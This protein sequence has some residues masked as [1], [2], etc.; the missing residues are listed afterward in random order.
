MGGSNSAAALGVY[1]ALG[2]AS[3]TNVPGSREAGVSWADSSG[4]FWM[5]GGGGVDSIG[6]HGSLNDLWEFNPGANQWTWVSGADIANTGGAYGM[7]G[8][9]DT[10]NIP[11]ARALGAQWADSA[12]NLW[13]FGGN[14]YVSST[15]YGSLNDLWEF[16]PATKEWTWVS[17]SNTANALAVYGTLGVAAPG[18]VPSGR[19]GNAGWRD[20]NGKLW[21]FG[22][23]DSAFNN[24]LWEFDPTSNEWTWMGGSNV[25]NQSGVYGTQG[26]ASANNIPGGREEFIGWTDKQGNFWV[27]GGWGVDITQPTGVGIFNDLWQ[28]NPATGAWTWVSG[29]NTSGAAGV[30]GTKGATSAANVPGARYA[31]AG[32]TDSTGN[33]WLFGGYSQTNNSTGNGLDF[34]DL[35]EFNITTK[36]WTWVSG[37]NT[38]E[39]SGVYGTLGV[40]AVGNTPGARELSTTWAD[41]SG[42]LWLFGGT[43]FSAGTDRNDLWRWG[44][45]Q[46]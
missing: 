4:N 36:Q 30:Y 34:N 44:L 10:S 8:V 41:G 12:G 26:V 45:T 19:F 14:G 31:S 1:G 15:T 16:N 24:D 17:G 5:F 27:F 3:P 2:V 43:G 13:L 33:L 21:M 18:N 11:G 46:P 23:S 32:W 40:G 9:P 35:W 42:N 22:G 28:Y 20:N 29:S 6:T 25:G 39:A 7:L 37:S 38:P